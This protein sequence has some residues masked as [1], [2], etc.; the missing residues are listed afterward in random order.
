MVVRSRS[1]APARPACSPSTESARRLPRWPCP[2][3]SPRSDSPS[4]PT[5]PSS[6]S[7]ARTRSATRTRS[8]SSTSPPASRP[9]RRC[10]VRSARA[11]AWPSTATS[12][13]C[14]SGPREAYRPSPPSAPTSTTSRSSPGTGGPGASCTP[15]PP[16]T[17]STRTSSRSALTTGASPPPAWS[18]ATCACATSPR[19]PWSASRWPGTPRSA[20]PPASVARSVPERWRSSGPARC[21]SPEVTGSSAPSI[22]RPPIL[23]WPGRSPATWAATPWSCPPTGG[24]SGR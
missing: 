4:A 13:T 9:A 18:T 17:R 6:P 12:S 24:S 21:S 20:T 11:P 15:F 1:P 14:S 22:P 2:T 3:T 7:E 16:R 19:A 23:S 8:S 10:A 5:G